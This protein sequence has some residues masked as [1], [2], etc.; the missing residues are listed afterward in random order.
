MRAILEITSESKLGHKRALRQGQ[1]LEVGRSTITDFPVEH[2]PLM[3]DRHFL[4]RTDQ[5]ACY[6][7]DLNSDNGTS[8][9]GQPV[10]RR[11]VLADHDKIS[12]GSTT[13]MMHLIGADK[14]VKYAPT[15]VK[16]TDNKPD[17]TPSFVEEQS[18][19][20]VHVYQGRV[21]EISPNELLFRLSDS[22]DFFHIVNPQ[23][24]EQ[25]LPEDF[26]RDQVL[27]NWLLPDEGDDDPDSEEDDAA[28]PSDDQAK[29]VV[30]ED[31]PVIASLE[32]AQTQSLFQDHWGE[33]AIVTVLWEKADSPPLKQVRRCA[34]TYAS[35]SLMRPQLAKTSAPVVQDLML[36]IACVLVEG[37]SADS[38][39]LFSLESFSDPLQQIQ[40]SPASQPANHL[41]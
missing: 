30:P 34:G 9:N 31:T 7:E 16:S 22:F 5:R 13:F 40:L 2:D 15:T 21:E 18:Q 32:P 6:L 14:T 35:P 12:A 19:S 1:T 3:S 4:I 41:T 33:D 36:G 20:G 28:E 11:I 24:I 23:S 37:E 17:S 8:V 39:S 10:L 27:F 25:P 29:M 38:W 26:P